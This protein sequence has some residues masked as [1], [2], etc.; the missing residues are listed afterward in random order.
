MQDLQQVIIDENVV[1]GKAEPKLVYGK[2]AAS[3]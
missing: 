1:E 3:A 2:E